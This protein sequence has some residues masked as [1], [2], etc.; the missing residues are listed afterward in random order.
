MTNCTSSTFKISAPKILL[1]KWKNK[2]QIGRNHS[3]TLY[4]TKDLV[5]KYIY[6]YIY[7]VEVNNSIK[8][9]RYNTWWT[10]HRKDLWMW[11]KHGKRSLIITKIQTKATVLYQYTPFRMAISSL[12][13]IL[14]CWKTV[15]HFLM[16]LNIYLPYD[17]TIP[18]LDICPKEIKTCVYTNTCM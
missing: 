10:R 18:L 15:W 12:M 7:S 11:N 6:K 4:V 17:S 13:S 9:Q 2:P 5:P 3:Q 14:K 8:I 16:K 1:R